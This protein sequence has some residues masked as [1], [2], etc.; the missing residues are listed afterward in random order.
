MFSGDGGVARSFVCSP[1]SL[2]GAAPRARGADGRYLVAAQAFA[3]R[4]ALLEGFQLA[5]ETQLEEGCRPLLRRE[6]LAALFPTCV[7][8]PTYS[9]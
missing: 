4:R 7:I 9:Y 8:R 3:P 6:L 2:H 5:F 1:S